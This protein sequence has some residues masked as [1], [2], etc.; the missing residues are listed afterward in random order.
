MS[1]ITA[2]LSVALAI[3]SI[4]SYWIIFEKAGE[5]GWKILIPFYNLYIMYKIANCRGRFWAS[6]AMTIL[7]SILSGYCSVAG[8]LAASGSSDLSAFFF[9]AI[10]LIVVMWIAI[11]VISVTHAFMLAK[12]FGLSGG[13]GVGLWLLSMIFLPILA[14]NSNIRYARSAKKQIESARDYSSANNYY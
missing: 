14:F 2:F 6:F 12:A 5:G 9:V 8:F 7:V 11:Y 3:L 4:V 1:Y 10:I 13:F